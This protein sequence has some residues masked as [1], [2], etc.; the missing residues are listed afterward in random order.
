MALQTVSVIGLFGYAVGQSHLIYLYF[1]RGPSPVPAP[2]PRTDDGDVPFVTVQVPMYNERNVAGEVMNACA[3]FDWPPDR[4]E[5][6]IL[7]D[8][9]D[10]TA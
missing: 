5:L 10:D 2:M 3:A 4:L 6:Q 9:T 8:S 1:R 7:D